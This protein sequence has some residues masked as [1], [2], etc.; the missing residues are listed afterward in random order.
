MSIAGDKLLL[1]YASNEYGD[2]GS[3]RRRIVFTVNLVLIFITSFY[4]GL[5][6]HNL[7]TANTHGYTER[8]RTVDWYAKWLMLLPRV[9]LPLLVLWAIVR[10]SLLSLHL[11]NTA[12]TAMVF[13]D[14]VIIIY[15]VLGTLGC[16]S[17]LW[18]RCSATLFPPLPF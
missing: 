15:I 5:V 4:A 18:P 2:I 14:F 10:C 9:L 16:N 13:V 6:L 12:I 17:S 8:V 7:P 11:M 1:R 3:E